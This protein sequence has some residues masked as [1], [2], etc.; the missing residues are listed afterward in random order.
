MDNK[1][2][3]N[4]IDKNTVQ[5]RVFDEKGNRVEDKP[6][7]F[8]NNLVDYYND[9]KKIDEKSLSKEEK[10]E[11]VSGL[12]D[13]IK[14]SF[15]LFFS[16]KKVENDEEFLKRCKNASSISILFLLIVILDFLINKTNDPINMLINI[17]CLVVLALT[18]VSLR[19]GKKNCVL[20]GLV[21]GV[22]MLLSFNIIRMI[23]GV[24]YIWG[25]ICLMNCKE[26]DK[27]TDINDKDKE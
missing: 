8:S 20:F 15:K 26:E 21:G 12:F 14:K 16:M 23:F 10:T 11:V 5:S 4:N 22:L 19:T 1:I 13:K 27:K 18:I 3:P 17:G 25:M 6:T 7:E 9:E 2:D 24:I